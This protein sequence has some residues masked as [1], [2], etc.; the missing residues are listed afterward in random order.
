MKRP[1]VVKTGA[2]ISAFTLLCVFFVR[3]FSMYDGFKIIYMDRSRTITSKEFFRVRSLPL[4]DYWREIPGLR[5]STFFPTAFCEVESSD[6]LLE[7]TFS[8]KWWTDTDAMGQ[9]EIRNM[10][11]G[12][13]KNWG[14]SHHSSTCPGGVGTASGWAKD[15]LLVSGLG[16]Y[17]GSNDDRRLGLCTYGISVPYWSLILISLVWPVLVGRR[18]LCTRRRRR[19]NMCICCGYCLDGLLSAMRCPECGQEFQSGAEKGRRT[20]S[21]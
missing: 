16:F 6:G 12:D 4:P 17:I 19:M 11:L 2:F 9:D 13:G 8:P 15:D 1:S 10:P 20:V 14:M 5:D 3:S 18:W 21:G 7:L